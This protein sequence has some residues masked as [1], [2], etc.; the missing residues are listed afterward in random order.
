VERSKKGI[1]KAAP[2]EGRNKKKERAGKKPW[3][4]FQIGAPSKR[5][6]RLKKTKG[7]KSDY[8]WS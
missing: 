1:L 6:N 2:Q 7:G 8:Q 3:G 4:T 5:K